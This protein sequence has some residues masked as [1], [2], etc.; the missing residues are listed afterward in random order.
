VQYS[1]L[2][3]SQV[4]G[5]ASNIPD[6]ERLLERAI[7]GSG[8]RFVLMDIAFGG[9][10]SCRIFFFRKISIC[11]T[12]VFLPR[13]MNSQDSAKEFFNT[14]MMAQSRW[15]S[16]EASLQVQDKGWRVRV[17]SVDG[18]KVVIVEAVWV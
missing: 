2:P 10:C 13:P 6:L 17:A 9:P 18:E 15:P 3:S 7:G 1:E 14:T 8:Q 4:L 11:S 12:S 5:S 16:E